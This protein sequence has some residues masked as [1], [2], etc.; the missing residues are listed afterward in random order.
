M[1]NVVCF[2]DSLTYGYGVRV[3]KV[4]HQLIK[5]K[6]DLRIIN[7]GRNG[8]SLLGMQIRLLGDVLESQA[9]TCLFMAG[10]N[11]LMMGQSL[12]EV[13]SQII[14][15]KEKI[16]ERGIKTFILSPP[17]AVSGMAEISWD[18]FPDYEEFNNNL[19]ELTI[20]LQKEIPLEFINIHSSFMDLP[21]EERKSLYLD[22]V[23]LN[24]EGNAYLAE[25]IMKSDIFRE[26][27][28]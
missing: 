3:E 20:L 21:L 10:S 28:L 17:P 1:K 22:G 16:M 2:G 14:K 13:H 23:H 9:D 12:E 6:L 18:S 15:I 11:D 19:Q 8:D 5:E 25:T 27:V 24:E 7:R 4:W 26:W